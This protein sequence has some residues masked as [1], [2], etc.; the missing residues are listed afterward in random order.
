MRRRRLRRR[1]CLCCRH[2]SCGRA[3]ADS[4]PQKFLR[5]RVRRILAEHRAELC[6]RTINLACLKQERREMYA[7]RVSVGVRLQ[8]L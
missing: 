4:P 1:L 3:R 2:L 7:Q 8:R 6:D 5:L